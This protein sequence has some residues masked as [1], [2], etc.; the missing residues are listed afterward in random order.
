MP[1][2]EKKIRILFRHDA[3]SLAGHTLE[4]PPWIMSLLRAENI[5]SEPINEAVADLSGG[6]IHGQSIILYA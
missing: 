5:S 6:R 4:V 1:L 2:S 3:Y